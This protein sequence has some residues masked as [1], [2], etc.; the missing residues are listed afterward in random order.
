VYTAPAS[1]R[2]GYAAALVGALCAELLAQRPNVFLVTDVL[3]ATSNA[4]YRR[5]GFEPLDETVHFAFM[6]AT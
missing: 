6:D 3:N 1:R 2:R 4:L 5:L